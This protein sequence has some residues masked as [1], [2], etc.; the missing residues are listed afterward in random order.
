M[1]MHVSTVE[2]MMMTTLLLC[3]GAWFGSGGGED[4]NKRPNT[5]SE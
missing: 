3:S 2:I 1:V 5:K 4:G